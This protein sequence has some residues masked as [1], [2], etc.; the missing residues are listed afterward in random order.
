MR[1]VKSNPKK[2]RKISSNKL[3]EY[4]KQGRGKSAFIPRK[5]RRTDKLQQRIE[6]VV[7][8]SPEAPG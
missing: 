8:K 5:T 1:T 6:M 4:A 7:K 3:A 2:H